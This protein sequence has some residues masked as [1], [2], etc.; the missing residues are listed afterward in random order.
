MDLLDVCATNTYFLLEDISLLTELRHGYRYSLSLIVSNIFVGY[1]DN[2][3]LD[4]H[5]TKLP[6]GSDMWMTLV[7]WTHGHK[8]L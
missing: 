8:I 6:Y 3:N 2:F 5:T 4:P 1:F 7:I